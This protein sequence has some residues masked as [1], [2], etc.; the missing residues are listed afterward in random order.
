M[1]RLSKRYNEHT[2]T[3]EYVNVFTG[4]SIIDSIIK[5]LSSNFAKNIGAK[6]LEASASAIGSR[7]GN[8]AIDKIEKKFSKP[9]E[10]SKPK[11]LGDVIVSELS[12]NNSLT[13][14]SSSKPIDLPT[15]KDSINLAKKR[16]YG[17]GT[18][19]KNF[20]SKLNKLLN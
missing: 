16:Y 11:P 7:V 15:Q 1:E 6:A 12:K 20:N 17:Y 13:S 18:L 5:K 3:Y 9:T 8:I 4:G 19:D 2:G 10:A 14:S